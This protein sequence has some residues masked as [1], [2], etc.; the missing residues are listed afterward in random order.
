MRYA[1]LI[2]ITLFCSCERQS[3]TAESRQVDASPQ[4]D[5]QVASRQVD[6]SRPV[7]ASRQVDRQVD[8]SRPVDET[9]ES[10]CCPRSSEPEH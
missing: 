6:A 5:R 8:A 9:D 1:F 3:G 10:V 2:A 7:D 4:V